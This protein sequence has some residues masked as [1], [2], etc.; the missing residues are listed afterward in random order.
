MAIHSA[1]R[2]PCPGTLQDRGANAEIDGHMRQMPRQ[3]NANE[4]FQ[5]SV[6]DADISTPLGKLL[7]P[8]TN[9]TT[10]KGRR[11]RG[12]RPWDAEDLRLLRAI[13]NPAFGL[14][15]FRN[16][17]VQRALYGDVATDPGERR[18]RVGRISRLFRMLRAHHLIEKLNST[19]RYRLTKKGSQISAAALRAQELS[20]SQLNATA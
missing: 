2:I 6:A 7:Q 16:V 8:I 19:R 15:G 11:V 9:P 13:A 1:D 4:H 20:L 3:R 18:R 12:L 10:W 14:N 17:D 5:N